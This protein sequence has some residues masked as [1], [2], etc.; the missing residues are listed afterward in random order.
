MSSKL[1][2]MQ[3][4]TNLESKIIS[5]L[6]FC[7]VCMFVCCLSV[8]FL[9]PWWRTLVFLPKVGIVTQNFQGIFLGV[10]KHHPW[11]QGWPC[12]PCLRSGT[13][14]VLKFTDKDTLLITL[15]SWICL[16]DRESHIKIISDIKDN[17]CPLYL[18]LGNLNLHLVTEVDGVVLGTLQIILK[19]WN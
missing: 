17:L 15:E 18:Q 13:T 8:T 12:P 16:T 2:P 19:S 3:K 5:I 6:N 9:L 1:H 10:Q 11:H 14:N 4:V 7:C